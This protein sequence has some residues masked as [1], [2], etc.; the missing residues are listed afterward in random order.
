MSLTNIEVKKIN[1]TSKNLSIQ[2]ACRKIFKE[3][4]PLNNWVDNIPYPNDDVY[5]AFKED[6]IIGFCMIHDNPP[7]PAKPIN[8]AGTYMYNLCVLKNYRNLG[9]A[10]LLLSKVVEDN[11]KC[12]LHMPIDHQLLGWITRHGW[13]EIG[14]SIHNLVEYSY[15]FSSSVKHLNSLKS[16]E[17]YDS[18]EN[19]IYL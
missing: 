8:E 2:K 14:S 19:I 18:D 9:V 15:G 5:C 17:H 1:F 3:A 6:E 4:W 11:P 12:Y 7:P 10:K 16:N 13:T